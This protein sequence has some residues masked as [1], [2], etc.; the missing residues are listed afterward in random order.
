VGVKTYGSNPKRFQVAISINKVMDI[1]F[2]FVI[3]SQCWCRFCIIEMVKVLNR[4]GV[5]QKE[6]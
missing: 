5:V 3:L 2:I 4:L 6:E 1:V